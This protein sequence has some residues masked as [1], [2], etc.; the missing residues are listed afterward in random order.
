M[1]TPPARSALLSPSP[2]RLKGLKINSVPILGCNIPGI[3]GLIDTFDAEFSHREDQKLGVSMGEPSTK[4]NKSALS[5]RDICTKFI[6]PHLIAAGWDLQTQVREEVGFTDGRIYVRGRLHARG[7]R[8]RADYIL[9]FKP[10]I[11]IALIEAKDNNHSVDAGIQQALAYAQTLDIPFV[12]SSNG[13][14]FLFHDKTAKSGPIEIKLPLNA[15]PS[16]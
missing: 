12:F 5:E 13:D 8:K 15:F 14:A 16:S 1:G 6:T 9:Y 10:N 3:K 2:P 7:A 4:M 11:P